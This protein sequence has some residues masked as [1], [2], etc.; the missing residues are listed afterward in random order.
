MRNASVV[1]EWHSGN[2]NHQF[3]VTSIKFEYRYST[4]T[5]WQMSEIRLM[6]ATNLERN[7]SVCDAL[8]FSEDFLRG[9]SFLD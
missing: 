5:P 2:G 8:A 3:E 9:F 7:N 4:K 6:T 1:T